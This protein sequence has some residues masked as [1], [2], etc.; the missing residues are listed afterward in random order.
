MAV[1]PDPDLGRVL[2][3]QKPNRGNIANGCFLL[4]LGLPLLGVAAAA[5][6]PLAVRLGVPALGLCLG[7]FAAVM[8]WRNWMHVFLQERGIREYRHG[9]GRSLAYD[10]VDEVLYTS[11]RIFMHGSYIRTVQKLALRSGQTPG[12]LLVCTLLFKEADGRA[13]AEA[14][15][16]LTQVRDAVALPLAERL[17]K[18][19]LRGQTVAWAPGVRVG[20]RGVEA[21]ERGAWSLVEWREVSKLDVEQGAVRLWV[22]GGTR[23][24]LSVGLTEPNSYPAY[25][26]A[27]KLMR[28]GGT[29]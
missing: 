6:A 1:R 7:G 13:A 16:P 5:A 19:V 25:L 21:E 27:L 4:L 9:R 14:R 20:R 24:R 12:P 18:R 2:L 26:A 11:A 10:A 17:L 28:Q 8:L 3:E 15:T 23:P 22:P 29:G